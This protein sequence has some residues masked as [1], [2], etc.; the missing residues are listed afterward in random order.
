MQEKLENKDHTGGNEQERAEPESVR[1]S[2]RAAIEEHQDDSSENRTEKETKVEKETQENKQDTKSDESTVSD[3]KRQ[4][5]QSGDSS[6]RLPDDTGEIS[7]EVEAKPDKEAKAPSILPKEIQDNW[8]NIP[9]PAR[10]H[11]TKVQKE[12]ADT[13]AD[14][15]RRTAHYK[16]LDEAIAPYADSIKQM[17]VTPAQTI[18]R[19]FQ[20]MNELSGP[21]KL[22]VIHQLARNFGMDL[23]GFYADV[24]SQGGQ[25]Q[26][27][28]Q[29]TQQTQQGQQQQD[30]Q[31]YTDPRLAEAVYGLNEELNQLKRNQDVQRQ[32]SAAATVNTWAGLQADGSYS[33]KPH[34]AQVRQLMFSLLSSGAVPLVNGNLDLDA[35]YE[36]ACY[37]HPEIRQELLAQQEQE[38]QASLKA[39]AEKKAAEDRAKV[40]KANS[41]N[42]SLRPSSPPNGV[43]G[44]NASKV[45]KGNSVRDSIINAMREVNN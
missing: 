7:K 16:D 41:L 1:D 38:K 45:N 43:I 40:A 30:Q 32:N 31:Y 14:L 3:D 6:S 29:Q 27:Q 39:A 33:K 20:W 11:F 4:S 26:Q 42:A 19:L 21:N 34:F 13:K 35:A 9:E 5:K 28:L 10:A 25:Q 23:E 18:S 17:G 24:Y 22:D 15:G 8:N 12:L 36:Q 2:I 44:N 37:S